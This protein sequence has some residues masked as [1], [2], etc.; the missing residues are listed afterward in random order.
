[1]RGSWTRGVTSTLKATQECD[2][3]YFSCY[4]WTFNPNNSCEDR[5]NGGR[6][7][8]G[9]TAGGHGRMGASGF[10]EM[11]IMIKLGPHQYQYRC[12]NCYIAPRATKHVK[13]TYIHSV[14]TKKALLCSFC[15]FSMYNMD[16]L[17]RHE[18]EHK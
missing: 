16:S 2:D 13:D 14:H 10:I 15:H 5:A 12:G 8:G 4:S 1:M 17:H 7:R 11:P 3:P 6:R 9:S 18:K